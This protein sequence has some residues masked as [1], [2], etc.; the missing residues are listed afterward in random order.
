MM[1]FSSLNNIL[2]RAQ[3]EKRVID[4]QIVAE[5]GKVGKQTID[6]HGGGFCFEHAEWRYSVPGGQS[7]YDWPKTGMQIT[8][9]PAV[10]ARVESPVTCSPPAYIP[11]NI[12]IEVCNP[13]GVNVVVVMKI[14]GTVV[15][16]VAGS[17]PL[18]QKEILGYTLL[19]DSQKGMLAL[20]EAAIDR[21]DAQLRDSLGSGIRE[22]LLAGQITEAF[23]LPG[24]TLMP[25]LEGSSQTPKDNS[26][27][28]DEVKSLL[29]GDLVQFKME[30]GSELSLEEIKSLA[31]YLLERSWSK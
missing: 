25:A 5:A 11:G 27:T 19:S 10:N 1:D 17:P 8:I 12:E 24:G 9:P 22:K 14:K 16:P 6:L 13:S 28:P 21:F 15:Q 31:D 3:F 4:V 26:K 2:N 23:G 7:D 18:S 29:V 30:T 20:R